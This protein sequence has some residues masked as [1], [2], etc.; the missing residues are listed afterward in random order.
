[1]ASTQDLINAANAPKGGIRRPKWLLEPG[2]YPCTVTECEGKVSQSSG[3]KM[4]QLTLCAV[5]GDEVL[6][7]KPAKYYVM[8]PEIAD[9]DQFADK[10]ASKLE[11]S[12]K[13]REKFADVAP[14]D[15][16][17]VAAE[18]TLKSALTFN[19]K[20][21]KELRTL[22]GADIVP[23]THKWEKDKKI[24]VDGEG[25]PSDQ[26]WDAVQAQRREIMTDV[27]KYANQIFDGALSVN[28]AQFVMDV[29]DSTFNGKQTMNVSWINLPK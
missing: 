28:G 20:F 8:L 2:I 9:M 1:M 24:V 5:D 13:F 22:L 29:R 7:D 27:V 26:S 14:E 15:L 4:L 16:A 21:V 10:C 12:A 23:D 25:N 6:T 11:S 3:Q 17:Q 19:S 18:D